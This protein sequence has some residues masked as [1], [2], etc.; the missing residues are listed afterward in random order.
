MLEASLFLA[1]GCGG[2]DDLGRVSGTITLDGEPLA[3]ANV[4]F[5]PLTP[6]GSTSYG[7]TNSSGNYELMFSRSTTGASLGETRVRITTFDIVSRDGRDVGLPEK[8]PAKFNTESELIVKV[9]PGSNDLDFD[10]ETKGGRVDQ[11]PVRP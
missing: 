5:E 1:L 4:Q 6:G 7:K 10:L 3:D 9:A 11:P 2:R 8:V